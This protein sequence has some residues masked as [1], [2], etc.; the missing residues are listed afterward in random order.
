MSASPTTNEILLCFKTALL[1][2]FGSPETNPAT[3]RAYRTLSSRAF[4]KNNPKE[5]YACIKY[6]LRLQ[7]ENAEYLEYAGL[8][9]C[10]RT[11]DKPEEANAYFRRALKIQQETV[12]TDALVQG[13]ILRELASLRYWQGALEESRNLHEQAD[14]IAPFAS[15]QAPE[16]PKQAPAKCALLRFFR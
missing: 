10:N 3:A 11:V 12:P 15:K 8:L 4:F 5:A 2:I 9:A 13:R 16:P 7:P 1:P 6:A 14:K